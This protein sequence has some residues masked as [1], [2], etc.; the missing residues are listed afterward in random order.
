MKM[1]KKIKKS[2]SHSHESEYICNE[3]LCIFHEIFEKKT[4][5]AKYQFLL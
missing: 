2:S 4:L 3:D 5:V 1:F